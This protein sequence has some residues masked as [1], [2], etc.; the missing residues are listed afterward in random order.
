MS[1]GV[2]KLLKIRNYVKNIYYNLNNIQMGR[3]ARRFHVHYN[4]A[5]DELE[6]IQTISQLSN[7]AILEKAGDD[8]MIIIKGPNG[9]QGYGV[10]L[11]LLKSKLKDLKEKS[12]VRIDDLTGQDLEDFRYIVD[13]ANVLYQSGGYGCMY[14]VINKIFATV[15][16]TVPGTVGAYFVGCHTKN[17]SFKGKHGCSATCA[18]SFKPPSGGEFKP[19]EHLVVLIDHSTGEFKQLNDP[20][21]KSK[22]FIHVIGAKNFN[23]SKEQTS[24]LRSW[25]VRKVK[26]YSYDLD[27]SQYSELTR[28][29][30]NICGDGHGDNNNGSNGDSTNNDDNGSNGNTMAF[31]FF[32]LIILIVV[33][34]AWMVWSGKA[35]SYIGPYNEWMQTNGLSS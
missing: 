33:F 20:D 19:C 26:V 4:S 16:D 17:A 35:D 10:N 2:V 24:K 18:G 30:V 13:L 15:H 25:G 23:L 27:T 8:D 32:I 29:F 31:I 6:D 21:D 1:H 9:S 7:D 28:G 11:N 34:I 22:A 12:D 3:G 14:K 5:N